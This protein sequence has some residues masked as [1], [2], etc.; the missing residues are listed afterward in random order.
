M[1]RV[2][3]TSASYT[4]RSLIASAQRCV[5]LYPEAN[6]ADA[7][8]PMTFYGTPGRKLHS[9]IPGSGGIR[10][11]F[12]ASNK[13]LFAVRGAELYCLDAGAWVFVATLGSVTGP[14]YGADNGI[15]A[16]FVDG[17]TT[18][19]TVQLTSFA[20]GVMSGEGWYGSD[21]VRFR[22]GFFI[23]NKPGTQIYYLTG[24]YDL[25]LDALDFASAEALPDELVCHLDDH[26][27][28]ILF[29][30]KSTEV[31]SPSGDPSFPFAPI[32]GAIMEV[33]CVAKHSPCKMDNS[34]FWLGS[35][36]RGDATVWRMQG[37][38]PQR[39]GNHA[40]EEEMRTYSRIDDA[41]GFSYQ[42]A[43]HSW[44]QLTFPTAGKT[45]CFDA[46]TEQWH[47]RA[48]R[49]PDNTLERVRDNC[50]V[51][52]GRKHLVGDWENGRVFELDLDTYTDDGDPITRV[53]SFQHM[54]ADNVRQFFDK[55]TIDMEAGVGN[56]DDPDPQVYLRWS[57]DGGKTWSAILSAP[58]GQVGEFRNKA[59]FNRLGMGRDRVFEVSTTANAKIALQGAFIEARRGTS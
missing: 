14:V 57:D 6:S 27:D 17:T 4:S 43:G 28:L 16:V 46:A 8:E 51:F 35:D 42:M 15:S 25:T 30:T 50:H 2:I 49:K 56:A 11:L 53:K 45:W 5:N 38:Q 9:T 47:E 29:G 33:G 23:F 55:L 40:L 44:Y 52:T 20:A 13:V 41:I 39:K 48:Y 7:A 3:L 12:E 54:S 34:V 59:N 58:I 1:P 32:S 22:N 18:A 37:Y 10:C 19:P 31:H 21:F 36:E 24:A 26:N